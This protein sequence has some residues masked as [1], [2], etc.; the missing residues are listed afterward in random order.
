MKSGAV[1]WRWY[2]VR[3]KLAEGQGQGGENRIVVWMCVAE[4]GE[5]GG[6]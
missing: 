1:L 2:T 3:M 4:L 5:E 6:S